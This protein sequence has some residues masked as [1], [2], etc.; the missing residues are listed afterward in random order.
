[1][2]YQARLVK[3]CVQ[4]DLRW[5]DNRELKPDSAEVLRVWGILPKVTSRTTTKTT[6]RTVTLE[7]KF[8]V[9]ILY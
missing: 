7:H 9:E 6:T 5:S 2:I 1:M 8:E 3:W 4:C